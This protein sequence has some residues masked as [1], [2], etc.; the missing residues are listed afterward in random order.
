M[1][2]DPIFESVTE[3]DVSAVESG[4]MSALEAGVDAA[5]I[6]NE[7]LIPAMDKVG[8]LFEEGEYFVPEMLIAARSMQAGLVILKPELVAAGIEPI[9]KV[10]MGTV[11]GDLHDIGKNLVSMMLEGAGFE[12]TDLGTN[13]SPEKFVEAAKEGINII[14][15]SALLTTTMPAMKMTIDAFTEAGLRDKVKIIIGGAPVTAE[16]AEKIGADGFAPDAS[17][18]VTLAKSLVAL[19]RL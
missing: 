18:A 3:G 2:L 1:N 4:V 19:R 15:L 13:V 5:T 12:I 9:G 16:Y 11:K 8:S 17:Q 7:A 14:G 10:L 6:L